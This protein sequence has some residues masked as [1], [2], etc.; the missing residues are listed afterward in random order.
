M[1]RRT[2]FIR[3]TIATLAV[4]GGVLVGV[5]SAQA[6]DTSGF[7]PAVAEEAGAG[8][9][10]ATGLTAAQAAERL[11]TQDARVAL[12]ER[13]MAELGDRAAGM[14]LDQRAGTVV[15]D[16]T[17]EADAAAVR[18]A[19]ATARVVERGAAELEAIRVALTRNQPA[20]TS[21]GVDTAANQIV[22][23]IGPKAT[24][25]V[26]ADRAARYGAAV[27]VEHTDAS[28]STF[29]EGG[30][31]IV[32]ASGGRCS[33]GFITTANTGLTAGHCTQGIPQW[34]EG[35]CGG[36]YYGPSIAVNFPGNDFGL[37]RND[38]GLPTNGGRVYLY[39]GTAQDIWTAANPY[40][41]LY[42]CKSGST[43]GLTCGYVYGVNETVCYAQ[44][45][46]GGLAR[47]N[48]YAA[49]GDSGGPWFNG[50]TAVGLTSGGGGGWTYFQPVV[51]ALNAYGIW[52][53]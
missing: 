24:G 40:V 33:L 39:N 50:G 44:G 6:A 31:P 20:D 51:P 38:G 32:G 3:V 30:Y 7:A 26:L 15:V 37:I 35:C 53:V 4:A 21:V 11:A 17:D 23:R 36:G 29:I 48:A 41:N 22:V 42:V 25:S 34:W 13:V 12:G 45:C 49:P 1:S 28:F 5:P 47:S 19:G 18:K 52:V 9:A 27:R 46:V 8:L 16:V 2:R 43:T 14:W 10:A